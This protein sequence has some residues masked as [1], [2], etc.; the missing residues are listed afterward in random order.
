MPALSMSAFGGKADIPHPQVSLQFRQRGFL[1]RRSCDSMPSKVVEA[2]E[3]HALIRSRDEKI[4]QRRF[5][6][7]ATARG[8]SPVGP[9]DERGPQED[10]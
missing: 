7:P 8:S 6:Q 10:G 4:T 1:P 5:P 2:A 3:I 9:I